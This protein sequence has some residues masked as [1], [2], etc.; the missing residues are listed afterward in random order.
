[1]KISNQVLFWILQTEYKN[2]LFNA[3]VG[4]FENVENAKEQFALIEQSEFEIVSNE[5]KK[6]KE[7]PLKLFDLKSL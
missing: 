2:T 6:G 7:S 4:K 3:E 5:T 1:M